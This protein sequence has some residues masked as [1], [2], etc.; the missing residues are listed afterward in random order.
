VISAAAIACY[1]FLGFDAV[2]TLTEDTRAPH[3]TI[4][5]VATIDFSYVTFADSAEYDLYRAP[6]YASVAAGYSF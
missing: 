5:C 4:P 1:S 6:N 3:K 2:S